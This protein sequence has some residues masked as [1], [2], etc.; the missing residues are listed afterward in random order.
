MTNS[1]AV[2][3]S[4]GIL[5]LLTALFTTAGCAGGGSTEYEEPA[6]T[7]DAGLDGSAG[8]GGGD[9]ASDAGPA[10]DA[11]GDGGGGAIDD[12]AGDVDPD[13]DAGD[14]APVDDAGTD[15]DIP[16]GSLE[17][18][19]L[20]EAGFFD[21]CQSPEVLDFGTVAAGTQTKRR[22]RFD[23]EMG[24]PVTIETAYVD[25][26]G[27]TVQPLHVTPDPDDPDAEPT[28]ANVA[29]PRTLTPGGSLFFDVT[30]T[31]TG[32]VGGPLPADKVFVTATTP[33]DEIIDVEV[34]IVG[35]EEAC[36]EGFAACDAD[37]N[38]GCETRLDTLENCG[39]CGNSCAF[40]N[41][42]AACEEGVCKMTACLDGFGDCNSDPSDGCEANLATDLE[43][44]SA[45]NRACELANA[46]A[47]C[48]GGNCL[49]VACLGD[50]RSCD[51]V[52]S[53]GCE[54]DTQ[55]SMAHCGAC[56]SP[57]SYDNASATCDGG[58][59]V[60]EGC[61]PGFDDC[62]S[63]LSDGCETRIDTVDNCGEC[64]RPCV[65]ANASASC[66][67][68]A[69]Q[70]GSCYAGFANCNGDIAD[71]CET[72]LK[73]DAN[74]GSCGNDCGT[75]WANA[76]GSCNAAV[77]S[78]DFGGCKPG[79]FDADGNLANGCECEKTSDV[80]EPDDSFT[81]SNCDGIDGDVNAAIFVA[82]TGNDANPGT[83]DRP[84]ATINAG[85]AKAKS[86][87]KKQ[88]YVSAGEYVGRV[89]LENGISIYGG[90]SAADGWKRSEAYTVTIRGNA[91]QNGRMSAV[92]G[93]DITT[94]T[95]LDRITIRTN[96]V[97]GTNGTSNYGLHCS[98]CSGL[99]IKN[100]D[101]A[102]GDAGAGAAGAGGATGAK[103]GGGN[104]GTPG[105]VDRDVSATGGAGGTGESTCNL[106]GGKGGDGGYGAAAGGKGEK[107]QEE[108]EGGN[109]GLGN[110]DPG[111]D[112]DPGTKGANG[113]K[114]DDG[115]AGAGG[116][117]VSG[118][119][120]GASGG[121]GDPG[122]G[123]KGGGG[124]G[125]G[126]GQ[127]NCV[128]CFRGTG[129]GGGGGGAGGCGGTP[130]FG[131]TAGG[132]SFGVFLVNSNGAQLT[133]NTISS[134]A[135]GNGGAGGEGGEGGEGGDGGAGAVDSSFSDPKIRKQVGY[136]G[137]GGDGGKGGRGG[138]GGGGAGGPS[139]AVYRSG[140]AGVSVAGNDL[141]PGAGGMGGASL[142][143][144]GAD[145]AAG[146]VN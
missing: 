86:A 141:S 57:C 2:A 90:Y 107:G 92:E 63:D 8:S 82:K 146:T 32:E 128:P 136:G 123:G 95:I 140:S 46:Q 106:E 4:F 101:I 96:N 21:S 18:C 115:D 48:S 88:V 120:S 9:T 134:G 64:G 65:F 84:V 102:A 144:S 10:D 126:G 118:F 78:C 26:E 17:L 121:E 28:P 20:N 105:H 16:S 127:G 29:L 109:G 6:P 14:G 45:C 27:F 103:G 11:G 38:N 19:V 35:G 116:G 75:K 59:C 3:P 80:D 23:N 110:R 12:D 31:S 68:G 44:C 93:S 47:A 72:S 66:N 69:C 85:L 34:P 98:Q 89:K 111:L 25:S 99:W 138:H 49:I 79:F 76:Y 43:H 104:P 60:F 122:T 137:K 71:G 36:A 33:S 87:G 119:W 130:G 50:Y 94:A 108:T 15:G 114:G 124:G 56:G 62:N 51:S 91:V 142:G 117:V 61:K 81:D 70:M 41:A 55:S 40:A 1:R 100:S 39:S 7:D 74:C 131:G 125:G 30:F 5:F 135:G 133:N 37:P 112:G 24:E 54:T 143:R 139:F 67:A 113:A 22:F 53:T 83:I 42:S 73:T 52:S 13:D 77:E 145:G 97:G 58:A 132:G 129:H